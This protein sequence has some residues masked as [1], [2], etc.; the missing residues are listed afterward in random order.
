MRTSTAGILWLTSL[1]CLAQTPEIRRSGPASQDGGVREVLESIVIPP[2]PNVPFTATLAT[3]ATKYTADGAS[4]TYVNERRIAR[5]AQGRLYQERWYLIPKGGNVKSTM[6]WIQIEDPKQRTLY[7][8][9]TEKH[10]CDLLVWDFARNLAAANPPKGHSGPMPDGEGNIVWEDLGAQN[11]AGVDTVGSRESSIYNAGTW[12]NDQPVTNMREY[13]HSDRLGINL[14]SIRTSPEFG[15]Q[16]FRITEITLGDP[17]ARL[18]R[19]PTGYKV[20]DQRNDTR[21]SH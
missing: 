2:L 8:C 20:N 4:M 7:N 13:W 15:K 3:E 10:V 19:V 9:S 11:I 12:G 1:A 6:N 16:T 5:D 14:L 17:D 21:I 18:F